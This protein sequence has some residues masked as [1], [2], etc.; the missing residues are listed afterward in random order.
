M[1][2]FLGI[3]YL[4]VGAV[5][6]NMTDKLAQKDGITTRPLGFLPFL[7]CTV[8]W[9]PLTVLAYTLPYNKE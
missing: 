5:M 6:S 3:M 1:L 9:F 7:I 8:L 4:G 2:T